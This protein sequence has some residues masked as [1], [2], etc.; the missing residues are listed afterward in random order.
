MKSHDVRLTE[1]TIKNFKSINYGVISLE[2]SRRL[3]QASV[4]GIYGQNGSGKT[5]VIDVLD[6]LKHILCGSR[7]PNKFADFI[8]VD[9]STASFIFKFSVSLDKQTY[10]V[11]YQ[12]S[13]CSAYDEPTT[14]LD[15]ASDKKQSKRVAIFNELLKCPIISNKQKSAKIGCLIDTNTNILFK[16]NTKKELL[17]GKDKATLDDLLFTKK[18]CERTSCSFIFSLGLIKAIEKQRSF[19]NEGDDTHKELSFYYDIIHSLIF[20]GNYELFVITTAHSSLIGFDT[21]P[22]SFKIT[23]KYE[24]IL[25]AIALP[26]GDEPIMIDQKLK[27]IVESVI[28]SLNT[29]LTE[30]VPGLTISIKE[31]GNEI[32]KN[33]QLGCRLQLL[34]SR[35]GKAIALKYE[36]EG[37]KKIISILN[38]LI[39]V[40]NQ[41]S[42][43]VAIDELDAGIFEYLLGELL[44]IISENGKGQLIFTSHNLRPLETLDSGFVA[45]TTTNPGNRFI[46]FSKV[47]SNNN[48]RDLYYRDIMLN[49]KHDDL[50]EYTHNGDIALAFRK[51]GELID[52][53]KE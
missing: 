4:L 39:C 38:L 1:I 45:F 31:L 16:P 25:G 32:L 34:S 17:I 28:Q 5:A 20:Y 36:S 50:Y 46:R 30:I 9:S 33:G 7:I 13:I 37:I 23:Y 40:Y 29:V 44:R 26:L 14:N 6:L 47:K 2:N 18:M 21:Q 53:S 52:T 10:P 48:L 22:F 35:G 3:T 11:V 8:N 24:K 12:F 19:S 51:A 49:D 27:T 15:D 41:P 43:T 42:I